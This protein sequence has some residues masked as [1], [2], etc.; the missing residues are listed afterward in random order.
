MTTIVLRKPGNPD[1]TKPNAY[2]P[3]AL[4][5]TLGKVFESIMADI[6]S[7][8]TETHELLPA[9]HYGGRPGRSAEDAIIICTTIPIRILTGAKIFFATNQP[10]TQVWRWSYLLWSGFSTKLWLHM[11]PWNHTSK[12]IIL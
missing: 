2:R 1:Y 3:I 7:Y 8:L 9:Q 10:A 5:N 6:I 4:E 11:K 12:K